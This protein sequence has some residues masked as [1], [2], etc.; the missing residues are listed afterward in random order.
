MHT[1]W[2]NGEGYDLAIIS[3]RRIPYQLPATIGYR[4]SQHRLS[5]S[6]NPD[7]VIVQ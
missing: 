5:P 7:K 3:L 1:I 2:L 4:P 6:G